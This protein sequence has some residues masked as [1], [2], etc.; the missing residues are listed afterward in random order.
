[1]RVG[2]CVVEGG[3]NGSEERVG[4]VEL[5]IFGEGEGGDREAEVRLLLLVGLDLFGEVF[6]GEDFVGVEDLVE[7]ED[8]EDGE[9]LVDVEDLVCLALL[10]SS[11]EAR[12]G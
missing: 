1:V 10:G 2:D 5:S 12:K 3:A 4:G 6:V 7:A 11:L 9:D 8:L